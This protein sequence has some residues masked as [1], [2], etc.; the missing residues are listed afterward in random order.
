LFKILNTSSRFMTDLKR[1][2]SAV[3]A[4]RQLAKAVQASKS[5]AISRA[6]AVLRLLGNSDVPLG[7]R[8][9]AG[10]LGMVPSTCLYVLRALADGELV[11]FDSD[12][13]RY[14]LEVGVLTLARHWLSHNQFTELA[15]PIMDRIAQSFDVTMIGLQVVG[16]Q[17]IVV[18]AVSKANSNMQLSMQIGSHFPALNSAS[19]RCIAA[20]GGYPESDLVAPFG[21]LRWDHAPTFEEWKAQV[22]QTR[23]RGFAVDD[24]CSISGVTTVAAP[25][26]TRQ[27]LSHT[28]V[29]VGL[30]SALKRRGLP[31]LQK[32]TL[33]A[34]QELSHQLRGEAALHQ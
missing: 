12:T 7:L 17:H 31:Q 2:Q 18:T 26:W 32:A 25:V 5:P 23:G 34:A 16:L 21:T 30:S 13:K 15:Q 1:K 6:I 22:R 28:I 24:G 11:S 19:G 3:R 9:I 20:F 10:Q 27:Q 14:S 33:A 29:A 8:S 4:D